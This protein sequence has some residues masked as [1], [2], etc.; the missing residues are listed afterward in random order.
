MKREIIIELER[1]TIIE[2]KS[3][4]QDSSED[5]DDDNIIEV[6]AKEIIETE[7]RATSED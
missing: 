4:N 6:E 3:L 2:K 1:V 7:N 5:E